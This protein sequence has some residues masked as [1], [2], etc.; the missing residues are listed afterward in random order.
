[1]IPYSGI[2]HSEHDTGIS[3]PIPDQSETGGWKFLVIKAL[4]VFG[5]DIVLWCR[6]I[7]KCVLVLLFIRCIKVDTHKG[8]CCRSMFAQLVYTL[9]SIR[10]D[11]APYYGTHKEALSSLINLILLPKIKRFNVVKHFT[12]LK[13]CPWEWITIMKLLVH[14]KELCSQSMPLKQNPWCVLALRN[15]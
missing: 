10:S 1:M 15:I 3:K 13:F 5:F 4:L 8:F 11:L 14:M 9:G 6:W 12:G 2:S 7:S